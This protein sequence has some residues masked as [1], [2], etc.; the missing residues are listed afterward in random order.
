MDDQTA[1][2]AGGP[3]ALP[4]SPR[5]DPIAG[6]FVTETLD[7]DGGR[8]VTV[9]VPPDPPEVVVFAGDGRG[10]SRWGGFLEAAA[11]P[12]TMIVG[13]H[14]LAGNLLRTGNTLSGR[15]HQSPDRGVGSARGQAHFGD[16]GDARQRLAPKPER[17]QRVY[18]LDRADLARRMAGEG[19]LDLVGR[20]PV[21]IVGHADQLQTTPEQFDADVSGPSIE[22]VVDQLADDRDGPRHDLA[23]RDLL[24]HLGRQHADAAKLSG[25]RREH[26]AG[27]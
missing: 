8:Q 26:A 19:Q 9:Y 2:G 1:G 24:R 4:K 22:R 20:D 6:E 11:V 25:A 13:V 12:S 18:I 27:G 3:E 7:Y 17:A 16:G 10:I 5:A 14:G 23:S 15:N 21:A